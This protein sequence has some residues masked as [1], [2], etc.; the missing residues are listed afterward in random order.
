MTTSDAGVH[1]ASMG[2]IWQCAVYGFRGLRVVG[3]ELHVNPRLPEAWNNLQ[4]NVTWRGQKL[5]VAADKQRVAIANEGV[6]D[7]TVTLAGK[8]TVIAAGQ[9]V[10]AE[11]A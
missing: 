5:R 10:S 7:V 11:I 4:F 9:S 8:A 2:G 3:D 6:E 1:T